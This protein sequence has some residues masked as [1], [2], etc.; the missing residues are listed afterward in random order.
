MSFFTIYDS[1]DTCKELTKLDLIN[2][3]TKPY[4][5]EEGSS[6]KDNLKNAFQHIEIEEKSISI[7]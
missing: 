5:E 6:D 4:I 3:Y 7:I 2:R 1:E